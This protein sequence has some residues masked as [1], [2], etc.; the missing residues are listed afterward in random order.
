MKGSNPSST[1]K[2]ISLTILG[3]G[4]STGVP[5]I[6]CKCRVC[7]SKNP[8]NKRLRA[9]AWLRVGGKSFLI[10]TSPDLRQQAIRARIPRIDAVLYTHPHADHTHGI[11]ELRS[12]NAIQKSEIPVYAHSWTCTELQSKFN[13]IFDYSRQ[14]L[15]SRSPIPR[16][17]PQF[18]GKKEEGGGRPRL[19]LIEF[20]PSACE[21]EIL[22]EK[23]IPIPLP[24]GSQESV[25]YRINGIA[26]VTDCSYIPISSL[27]RMKE[28]SVLVLDCLRLRPHGTHLNL[29][30]A[31]EIVS[32]LKP[33]RTFLTHLGH[34]MDYATWRKKL[35]K[36]VSLAYDGLTIKT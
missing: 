29:D 32:V 25:G 26:Y 12:F 20:D 35:P 30:Q 6:Q 10:D 4:N 5:M 31:L 1:K 15:L 18:E 33:K 14:E 21:L 22:G 11:D 16:D 24:H 36:G 7:R 2:T 23:I 8:K 34:E 9:S 28:L 17:N 19:P 3:S 13:Y 27:D